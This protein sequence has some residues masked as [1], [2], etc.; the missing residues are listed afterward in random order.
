MQDAVYTRDAT[1]AETGVQD[2]P[3]AP[4]HGVL[5]RTPGLLADRR[6]PPATAPAAREAPKDYLDLY[7]LSK[8]PF[9]DGEAGFTLFASHRPAFQAL[10]DQMVGGSGLVLLTGDSG[11]GKT[12]MLDAAGD[13][14]ATAGVAV[15]RLIRPREG[16]VASDQLAD[17]LGGDDTTQRRVLLVDDVD[18]LPADCLAVLRERLA[19]LPMVATCSGDPPAGEAG[20][21]RRLARLVL[22]L[23]RLRPDEVRYYI[24]RSLWVGGGTTR[25]LIAADALKLIIQRSGGLPG[26]VNGLM[27][28]LFT[29]GFARGD[30]IL[31]ARTVAAAIG[32]RRAKLDR[33]PSRAIPWLA[34]VLLAMG[35]A[36]FVFQGRSGLL[37]EKPVAAVAVAP[38]A[39]VAVAPVA[40]V[41]VAPV[42]GQ[43]AAAPAREPMPPDLVVALMK[44]G[45]QSLAL[46]DIAAARMWF[47]H[48]AEAGNAAAAIATGKTYDPDYVPRNA[49]QAAR[50]D[51]AQAA[52]WY[53]RAA[54][55]GDPR[56]AELLARVRKP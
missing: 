40:A 10:V 29:A 48:A 51:P 47:Q 27:A 37:P 21:F 18:L 2:G 22:R 15:L 28:A 39:A 1:R 33:Q 52:A 49:A 55:L 8:P 41:A 19:A 32:Q 25:R 38:V 14:A 43:G 53:R 26:S 45:E 12:R 11:A 5:R 34:G 31:T 3:P 6:E 7:G 42:A 20:A 30:P 23:P 35:V 56:G 44:R 17:L 50:P 54:A 24:E 4:P 16:R 36:A 46:G 9:G 13:A